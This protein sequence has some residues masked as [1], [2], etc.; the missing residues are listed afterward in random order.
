RV[1]SELAPVCFFTA[2]SEFLKYKLGTIKDHPQVGYN[3]LKTVDF[4]WQIA[5][6]VLR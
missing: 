6:I 1:L 3:I 5:Q 4:P 2:I